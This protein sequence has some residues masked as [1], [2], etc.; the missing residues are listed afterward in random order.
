MTTGQH[1]S[2]LLFISH[3][4]FLLSSQYF[5]ATCLFHNLANLSVVLPIGKP[6]DQVLL[7]VCTEF[8]P[9]FLSATTKLNINCDD[10]CFSGMVFTSK[11]SWVFCHLCQIVLPSYYYEIIC[12][13]WQSRDWIHCNK[14][15]LGFLF[16]HKKVAFTLYRK[17]PLWHLFFS[18]GFHLKKKPHHSSWMTLL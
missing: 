13:W 4:Q 8:L 11:K 7:T 17:K 15:S 9:R 12:Q 18:C 2:T 6:K 5:I 14:V 16:V 3:Y 1:L 10:I